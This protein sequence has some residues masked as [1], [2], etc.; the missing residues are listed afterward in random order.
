MPL[1]KISDITPQSQWALWNI[2]E[3][4]GNLASMANLSEEDEQLLSGY[5]N[6][7]KQLEWLASRILVMNL[8]KR[9]HLKFNG[10]Q[11]DVFKKPSLKGYPFEIS[12]SH[13][14]PYACVIIHDETPVGIDIECPRNKLITVA[15]KFLNEDERS[16]AGDDIKKLSILWSAK[17]TLYKIHGKK[18]LSF[19]R[20]FHISPF[21]PEIEGIINAE[22][23]FHKGETQNYMLKYEPVNKHIVVFNI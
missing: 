12:I 17:E 18:R 20:H 21:E 10:I 7:E 3:S 15:D 5:R 2:N 13:S 9:R 1:I 19:R 8:L 14:F 4:F 16:F 6:H 22:I 23:R 11:K